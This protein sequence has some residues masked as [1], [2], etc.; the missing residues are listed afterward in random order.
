MTTLRGTLLHDEP[1]ARYTSWRVGG[2]AKQLYKPA[3]IEDLSHFLQTLLP[4]ETI[5]WL[6]LGSNTLVR[7]GGIAGTVIV[8]QGLLKNIEQVAED[9]IRAEA[10]VSCAA[11]ARYAARLNLAGMEF[12]AGV[13]GTIGGAL[14]MNAGCFGGETW[15][16][17]EKVTM[18]NVTGKLHQRSHKE[19]KVAYREV[20]GLPQEWFVDGYFKLEK[21]EK[22]VSLAAIRELLERRA[23]TQP[24]GEHNCGSV[25]RNPAGD[26]AGRLIEASG[27]KGYRIGGAFVSEKHS[28]FIINDGTATAADIENLIGYVSK[29]V[30]EKQGIE[31]HR[32]VHIIGDG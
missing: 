16:H 18:I 15:R 4:G 17:V 12:L 29:V 10:G 14:K 23:N 8:T 28:N 13:P 2:P 25:F 31:L 26:Y 5:V 22:E 20:N 9:I 1:L 30:A 11:M 19:F 6:G 21:G 7:D 27:L 3:D 24:T 32:E